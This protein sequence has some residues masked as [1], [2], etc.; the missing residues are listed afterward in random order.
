[1]NINPMTVTKEELESLSTERLLNIH[2]KHRRFD[3]EYM[4]TD[5]IE[6][7]GGWRRVCTWI[8]A[9]LADREHITRKVP[10][11]RKRLVTRKTRHKKVDE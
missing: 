9:I 5:N 8:K 6:V 10:A 4:P 7:E 2:Q 3:W 1:M 11:K